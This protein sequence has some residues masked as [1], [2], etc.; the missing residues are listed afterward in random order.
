VA[1]KRTSP[2]RQ[3]STQTKERKGNMSVEALNADAIAALLASSRT[4]GTYDAELKSFIE[5]GEAG[6]KVSLES[7][8]FAGKKAQSVKTGFESARKREGAPEESEHVR[9]ILQEDAVYLIRGDMQ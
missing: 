9:V 1:R 4:R 6:V 8:T 2:D 3:G 7:G 5:S